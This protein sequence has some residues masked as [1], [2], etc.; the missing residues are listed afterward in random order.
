[1]LKKYLLNT[2]GNFGIMF[3]LFSTVLIFGAGIAVDY[4]GMV[5]QRTK[6]QNVIDAAVLA[7][8]T[9]GTKDISEIQKIVD[10]RIALLNIKGKSITATARFQEGDLVIDSTSEYN[11]FLLGSAL[12][13]MGNDT[14]GTID[15][16]ASTAAPIA[17][18]DFINIALVLDTTDSMQG[19]NIDGLK[20][21]A[22]VLLT[23]LSNFGDNVKVSV[24]P[25]GQYVNIES[26]R[27]QG[28]LDLSQEHVVD[29]TINEPSER[30]TVIKPKEC[31]PTGNLIP[32][33]V[34]YQDG[35]IIGREPDVEEQDCI[36]AIYGPPETVNRNYDVNYRWH[37]CAGSRDG[38]DNIKAAFDGVE[39]PGAM[40]VYYTGDLTHTRRN[41]N[42][43]DEMLPLTN[44]FGKMKSLI[45]GLTTSGDT[46]LP[47]GLLWGWRSLTLTAPFT[48]AATSSDGTR[49]IMIFMTDGFNTLSQDGAYHDGKEREN[50]IVVARDIC[51]NIN[52]DNIDVYTIAYNIPS[53]DAAD[54]TRSLLQRCASSPS[55]SFEAQDVNQ[56]TST[57]KEI[58]N[59]LG[60][61]RLKYR[62]T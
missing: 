42:C 6:L 29:R 14:D 21:A 18:Q 36:P 27:G 57:F 38:E 33:D 41:A 48:E 3:A 58:V 1:M 46:Y 2:S 55:K 5:S 60:S 16:G 17:T 37:G 19:S 32:G 62:A 12:K 7:A 45:A 10:E 50:G 44:D 24:V 4:G 26:Q 53:I 39:I 59:Q 28:W 61:I 51:K 35:V 31:T 56:L 11:T 23:D 20:I 15:I 22:D 54:E 52:D 25:F 43:G 34:I 9:S 30:R 47:S 8:A 13:L 40:E 49:N